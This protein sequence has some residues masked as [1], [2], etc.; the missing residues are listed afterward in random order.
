ML[1]RR[2]ALADKTGQIG[3]DQL[4]KVAAALNLLRVRFEIQG[5]GFAARRF[6]I[7]AL[8]VDRAEPWPDGQDRQ[9][10]EALSVGFDGRGVGADWAADALAWASWPS[11]RG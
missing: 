8:D 5:W 11:A 10:D 7:Q 1:T 9:E 2:V 3:F 6:V 4:T